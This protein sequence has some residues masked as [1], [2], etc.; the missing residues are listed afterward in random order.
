MTLS[1]TDTFSFGAGKELL[2]A[3]KAKAV[4]VSL[5]H[6]QIYATAVAIL[7]SR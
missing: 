6:T 5:S 1:L 3:R 7:E 2:E 4:L